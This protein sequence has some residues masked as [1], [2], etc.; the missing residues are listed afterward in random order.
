[1]NDYMLDL[2]QPSVIE[3]E[4]QETVTFAINTHEDILRL[5]SNLL[6]CSIQEFSNAPEQSPE[7]F[8]G[9]YIHNAILS[10]LDTSDLSEDYT[11]VI[12]KYIQKAVVIGGQ[13][14][15]EVDIESE[16]PLNDN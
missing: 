16:E 13:L 7:Y 11:D 8:L 1:M 6:A 15:T 14:K 3:P 10:L 4:E 12:F 2:S 9:L 5:L